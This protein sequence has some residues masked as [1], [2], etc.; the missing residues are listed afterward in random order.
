MTEPISDEDLQELRNWRTSPIP[1]ETDALILRLDLAEERVRE[2]EAERDRAR[3][4]LAEITDALDVF[5]DDLKALGITLDAKTVS[6]FQIA[7]K[8]LE[9]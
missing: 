1:A 7:R 8:A 9:K 5:I 6:N 3:D 2:L 4:A